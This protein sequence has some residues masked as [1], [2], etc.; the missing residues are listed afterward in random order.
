MPT[1]LV[2]L[3]KIFL[4]ISQ[5]G[6]RQKPDSRSCEHDMKFWHKMGDISWL[7]EWLLAST[8]WLCPTEL[9]SSFEELQSAQSKLCLQAKLGSLNTLYLEVITDWII[10]YVRHNIKT[11][12]F[13]V[14]PYFKLDKSFGA[15]TVRGKTCVFF[16]T[17][18][19]SLDIRT[20]HNGN[21]ICIGLY[22]VR[23]IRKLLICVCFRCHRHGARY[24]LY[25][26]IQFLQSNTFRGMWRAR[27]F[28]FL[29]TC[30]FVS[31]P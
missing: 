6:S 21:A 25:K 5:A 24:S 15:N 1:K 31:N 12:V 7:C 2:G 16:F 17:K 10:L 13:H 29:F 4:K 30:L 27:E 18:R 9:I 14:S 23:N 20:L 8:E 26:S 19:R 28:L 11:N 22:S 3:L